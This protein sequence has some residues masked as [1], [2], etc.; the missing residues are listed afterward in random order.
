MPWEERLK[1]FEERGFSLIQSGKWMNQNAFAF[2]DTEEATGGIFET[3]YFP[4]D[5]EYP[6][7]EEW[8]PEPPPKEDESPEW[9]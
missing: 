9:E 3:Y 7:P 4:S 2:F 1:S 6:E 5:F 8:Y